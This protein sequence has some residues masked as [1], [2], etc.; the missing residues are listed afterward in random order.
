MNLINIKKFVKFQEFGYKS[1]TGVTDRDG[2]YVVLGEDENN[3]WFVK[4]V[5]IKTTKKGNICKITYMIRSS[6]TGK[7]VPYEK[8]GRTPRGKPT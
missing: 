8:K 5:E 3:Y 2:D 4:V 7:L 6:V 1:I